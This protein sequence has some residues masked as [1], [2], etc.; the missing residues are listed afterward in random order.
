[1]ICIVTEVDFYSMIV[2]NILLLDV[3]VSVSSV[4]RGWEHVQLFGE[5]VYI[6]LFVN[7]HKGIGVT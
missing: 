5:N 4:L 3:G 1:M 6:V 2:T 7:L